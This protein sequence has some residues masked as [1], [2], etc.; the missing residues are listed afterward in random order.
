MQKPESGKKRVAGS[1]LKTPVS[2][3]KAKIA[4]PSGQKTGKKPPCRR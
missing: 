4:T 1:V 2:D 3:K